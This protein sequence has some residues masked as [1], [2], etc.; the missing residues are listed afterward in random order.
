MFHFPWHWLLS[1]YNMPTVQGETHSLKF[2]N[3]AYI[4]AEY[5]DNLS[6]WELTILQMMKMIWSFDNVCIL[7][8]QNVTHLRTTVDLARLNKKPIS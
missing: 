1:S 7:A 4:S 8:D 6:D 3:A 5:K 2:V